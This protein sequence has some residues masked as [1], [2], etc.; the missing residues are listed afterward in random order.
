MKLIDLYPRIWKNVKLKNH[1]NNQ[2]LIIINL[3][4]NANLDF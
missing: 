4:F 3:A 1:C 2:T